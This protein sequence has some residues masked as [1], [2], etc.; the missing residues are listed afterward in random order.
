MVRR[1]AAKG[2]SLGGLPALP[3]HSI[4]YKHMFFG[5]LGWYLLLVAVFSV[6]LRRPTSGFL[7]FCTFVAK[8][9]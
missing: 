3:E 8:F 1:V 9:S 7:V 5:F 6:F 4:R 2:D